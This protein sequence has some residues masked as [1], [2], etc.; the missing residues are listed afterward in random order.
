MFKNQ[1]KGL[2]IKKLHEWF[3]MEFLGYNPLE[4]PIFFVFHKGKKCLT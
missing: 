3:Y 1:I 4:I 2:S